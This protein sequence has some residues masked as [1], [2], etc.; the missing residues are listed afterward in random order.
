MS[1]QNVERNVNILKFLILF[2]SPLLIIYK[3]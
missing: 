3:V 2:L 1:L